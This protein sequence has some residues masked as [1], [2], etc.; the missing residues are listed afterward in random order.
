[1][2]FWH[3]WLYFSLVSLF[4]LPPSDDCRVIEFKEGTKNKILTNHVIRRDHLPDKDVCELRCY[5]EPNCVSYNY[6]PL[7]DGTFT[8][9][10][11]DRTYLQVPD[12][13]EDKSGFVYTEIFV[14]TAWWHAVLIYKGDQF[15]NKKN[16]D[17]VLFPSMLFIYLFII[18]KLIYCINW[19]IFFLSF[20]NPCESIPCANHATCQAGFGNHGY[21]CICPA[22]YQGVQC[23]TGEEKNI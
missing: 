11:N 16:S 7:S 21:R 18:L 9:E 2:L 23:K 12:S 14:S 5:L 1:M 8:C 6:G 10:L 20:Q 17:I 22:G 13:L 15:T 3:S 19:S 4:L